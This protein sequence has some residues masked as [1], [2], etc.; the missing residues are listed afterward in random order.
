[1]NIFNKYDDNRNG[2]LE[3]RET[4][5]LLNELL[6]NRGQQPATLSQFN[7]FF[8]DIDINRDG[9]VSKLEMTD[10]IKNFTN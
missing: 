6:A 8:S 2:Y 7:Q 10:F 1:M 5:G 4:L 9:V 3:K